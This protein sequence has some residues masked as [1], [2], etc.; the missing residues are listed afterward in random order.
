MAIYSSLIALISQEESFYITILNASEP[1]VCII[2]LTSAL[3]FSL[4]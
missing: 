1:N 3:D 4:D 2:L